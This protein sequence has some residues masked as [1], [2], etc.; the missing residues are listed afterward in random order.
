MKN[1]ET[2]NSNFMFQNCIKLTGSAGTTYDGTHYDA[3]QFAYTGI[4]AFFWSSTRFKHPNYPDS[5]AAYNYDIT[6]DKAGIARDVN[7]RDYLIGRSVR[8]IRN[9]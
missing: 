2:G 1:V 4:W 9:N 5:G 8:C 6:F 3:D 7:Y